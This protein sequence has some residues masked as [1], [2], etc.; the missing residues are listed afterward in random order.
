MIDIFRNSA[1]QLFFSIKVTCDALISDSS[2]SLCLLRI[3]LTNSISHLMSWIILS[4]TERYFVCRRL[5]SVFLWLWSTWRQ[6]T[7][8]SWMEITTVH[9][10]EC[11]LTEPCVSIQNKQII[12]RRTVTCPHLHGRLFVCVCVCSFYLCVD[13]L[14]LECEW[15]HFVWSSLG[16]G[17]GK[18]S[19]VALMLGHIP[20]LKQPRECEVRRWCHSFASVK[21]WGDRLPLMLLSNHI[22]DCIIGYLS[23]IPIPKLIVFTIFL[24]S[25]LMA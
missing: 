10:A 17:C 4:E 23:A 14:Y 2:V 16:L 19:E 7:V 3:K 24:K 18:G 15:G 8:R 6:L 12:L 25:V 20:R 21:V 11:P 1:Y 5:W 22:Q 9:L 13:Q